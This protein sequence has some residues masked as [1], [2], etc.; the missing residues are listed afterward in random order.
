MEH[1]LKRH[2]EAGCNQLGRHDVC[3]VRRRQVYKSVSGGNA[4]HHQMISCERI[5]F[6]NEISVW[7]LFLIKCH[8]L[9]LIV[10]LCSSSFLAPMHSTNSVLNVLNVALGLKNTLEM[11]QDKPICLQKRQK[12]G[13]NAWSVFSEVAGTTAAN[14]TFFWT[15]QVW[16]RWVKWTD[17][18][19]DGLMLLMQRQNG[20]KEHGD[21]VTT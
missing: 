17:T 1:E 9:V 10:I 2:E 18:A 13:I 14:H 19:L 15:L 16:E 6:E 11:I 8:K 20:F 4:A 12:F 5:R 21:K 7:N 3:G